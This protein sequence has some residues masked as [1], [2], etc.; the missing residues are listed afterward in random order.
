MPC[1][2]E[3]FLIILGKAVWHKFFVEQ[4]HSALA[5]GVFT[6]WSS[7]VWGSSPFPVLWTLPWL[8]ELVQPGQGT[9]IHTRLTSPALGSKKYY[10]WGWGWVLSL[11]LRP[12][13]PIL[14][15]L[16]SAHTGMTM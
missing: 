8:Y 9:N 13:K 4:I 6:V 2:S 11:S 14:A 10:D 7:S 3:L 12:P 5:K 15:S 16:P 1:L